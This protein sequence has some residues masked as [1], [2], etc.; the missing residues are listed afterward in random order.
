[1]LLYLLNWIARNRPTR[2]IEA[3]N[4]ALYLLR[5]KLWGWMPGDTKKYRTSAYLHRFHLP[6]MDR[7][8]HNHPWRWSVSLILWGGYDEERMVRGK[9]ITRRVRPFRLNWLS[10][11]DFHRVTRLHGKET[12]TLFIAGRKYKGWGFLEGSR[13]IPYHERFK[14]RGIP[15]GAKT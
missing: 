3:E 2:R 8:L 9:A 6:D 14:E 5:V 7:A 1:M 4:G 12:W 15:T 10:P 13:F 11:H